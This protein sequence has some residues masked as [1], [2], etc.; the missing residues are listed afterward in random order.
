MAHSW[1][2]VDQKFYREIC[3][4]AELTDTIHNHLLCLSVL[5]IIL[6]ISTLFGNVL[7]LIGQFLSHIHSHSY[8]RVKGYLRSHNTSCVW[9]NNRQPHQMSRSSMSWSKDFFWIKNVPE[10]KKKEAKW[11]VL[12]K[13]AFPQHFSLQ[14]ATKGGKEGDFMTN[15][16]ETTDPGP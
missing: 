6:S 7:V 3:C 4:S 14:K 11:N 5:S 13:S 12:F 8:Q 9:R 1:M 2:E 15:V 10:K 16:T